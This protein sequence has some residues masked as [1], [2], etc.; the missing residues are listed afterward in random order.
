[1]RTIAAVFVLLPYFTRNQRV[2][3]DKTPH[4]ESL[5]FRDVL[6]TRSIFSARAECPFVIRARL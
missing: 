2:E 6:D 5:M 3:E 4:P 1:M